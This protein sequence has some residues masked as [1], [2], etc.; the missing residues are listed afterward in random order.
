MSFYLLDGELVL[1]MSARFEPAPGGLKA[2]SP[3]SR[4]ATH[5]EAHRNVS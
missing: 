1:R 2:S 4:E 3:S 5:R